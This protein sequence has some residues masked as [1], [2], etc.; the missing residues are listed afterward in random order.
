MKHKT[1]RFF[2][3]LS[4]ITTALC[5]AFL[6]AG[7]VQASTAAPVAQITAPAPQEVAFPDLTE[8]LV[9]FASLSGVALFITAAVNA[10]KAVGIVKDGTASAWSA[11]L[12]LFV[13]VGLIVLQVIGK[14]NL[15]PAI[16]KQAGVIANILTA[17]IALVVQIFISRKA[18]ES[19]LAGLP[20]VGTSNSGRVAGELGYII[21]TEETTGK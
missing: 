18:H 21:E 15:V 12:N 3:V 5:M 6:T 17:M 10:L 13:L 7:P 4:V 2:F 16:D 9:T 19:A 1:F 14:S 11:G 8:I 20:V